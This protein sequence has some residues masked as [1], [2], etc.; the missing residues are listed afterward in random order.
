M[1]CKVQYI[2]HKIEHEMIDGNAQT[3]C[4]SA[5][6]GEN[7]NCFFSEHFAKFY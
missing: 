6:K 2:T 4:K 1:I 3:D 5:E 7:S